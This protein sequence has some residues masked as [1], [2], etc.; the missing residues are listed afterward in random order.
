MSEYQCNITLKIPILKAAFAL[1]LLGLAYFSKVPDFIH[2]SYNANI[3]KLIWKAR[4]SSVSKLPGP[5]YSHYANIVLRCHTLGGRRIFYVHELHQQYGGVVR[6]APNEAAIADISGVTQIHKIGSGFL[7]SERY[8]E[9]VSLPT[10]GIFP[11]RDPVMHNSWRKL[12][13]RAFSNTNLKAKWEVE[14][15]PKASL[16]VQRTEQ[17]ALDYQQG[18]DVFKWWTL[19]ATDLITHLC[20]GES[21]N[22]LE[23]GKVHHSPL[24]LFQ[25]FL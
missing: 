21:F 24:Y 25:S 17:D 10:N 7:K 6:I 5:W 13:S 4:K 18:D 23:I 9:F 8:E 19:M 15:R 14:V 1:L 20:F 2:F 3:C 12:F 16:A 11:M 22:M